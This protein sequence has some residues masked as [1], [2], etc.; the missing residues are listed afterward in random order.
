MHNKRFNKLRK[1][2]QNND[3]DGFLV[4]LND[5]IRYLTGLKASGCLFVGEDPFLLVPLLYYDLFKPDF[6]NT[7]TYFQQK[8]RDDPN[9]HVG[10]L[11]SVL[12]EQLKSRDVSNV[13]VDQI[14]RDMS[15]SLDVQYEA[16]KKIE[17]MRMIKDTDEIQ[18]IEKAIEITQNIMAE[19]DFS[20]KT[21]REMIAQLVYNARIIAD[22]VAF[23]PI[24]A[25]GAN[26]RYPHPNIINQKLSEDPIMVDFGIKYTGYCTDITRMYS[27]QQKQKDMIEFLDNL[28]LELVDEIYLGMEFNE[29]DRIVREKLGSKNYDT[30]FI[31]SVGHGVGL[32]VHERPYIHN[33]TKNHVENG[34]V[35]TIEPGMYFSDFGM[36]IEKIV[37]IQ[38]DKARFLSD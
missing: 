3:S 15:K 11:Y 8:I 16:S 10:T 7:I 14:N 12:T 9:L 35:F 4:F 33:K 27:K 6:E 17:K 25:S 38:N 28:I 21:D 34:M 22:D 26:T 20:N 37:A 1:H 23:I 18:I 29:I 30:Y 31:H 32:S 5:N 19:I 2:A 13:L 24:V 36:R